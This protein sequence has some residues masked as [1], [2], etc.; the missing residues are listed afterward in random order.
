MCG[1][2]VE[3]KA[4]ERVKESS[5]VILAAQLQQDDQKEPR[6]DLHRAGDSLTGRDVMK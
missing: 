3:L 4:G 6:G 5:R 2:A 1:L